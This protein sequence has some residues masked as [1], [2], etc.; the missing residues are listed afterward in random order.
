MIIT[1]DYINKN[2]TEA[3]AWTRDQL[4]AIGVS[5]PPERGWQK[6]VEGKEITEEERKRFENPVYAKKKRKRNPEDAEA[7]KKLRQANRVINIINDVEFDKDN[8]LRIKHIINDQL[9]KLEYFSKD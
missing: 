6:L 5:W 2:R 9:D 3:G 1:K 7:K 4:K 8:L